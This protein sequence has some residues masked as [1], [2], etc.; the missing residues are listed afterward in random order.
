[1]N[2]KFNGGPAFP[3]Q[4]W[5][6]SDSPTAVNPAR[7][8]GMTLRDYF[9]A[10]AMQAFIAAPAE[11]WPEGVQSL[12]ISEAAYQQADAMLKARQQ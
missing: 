1:M 12:S 8:L 7:Y 3:A 2:I 9:A 6:N 10:Q 5:I 11:C 4:E